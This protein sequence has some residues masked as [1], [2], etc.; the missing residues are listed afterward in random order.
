MTDQHK[1]PSILS[2]EIITKWIV[3]EAL[4]RELNY[5]AEGAF[6]WKLEAVHDADD[7]YGVVMACEAT[8]QKNHHGYSEYPVAERIWPTTTFF[9]ASEGDDVKFFSHAD[10]ADGSNMDELPMWMLL[11]LSDTKGGAA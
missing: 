3:H 10:D 5:W 1:E 4:E 11:T 9:I 6:G 7:M 2:A 8:I